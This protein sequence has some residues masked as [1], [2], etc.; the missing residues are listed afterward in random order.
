MFIMNVFYSSISIL[1]IVINCSFKIIDSID[2]IYL[3]FFVHTFYLILIKIL[4]SSEMILSIFLNASF[5]SIDFYSDSILSFMLL[6]MINLKIE[7]F[8]LM[9]LFIAI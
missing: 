8:V 7:Y 1:I 3:L 2:L 6:E 9:I 5:S 4:S